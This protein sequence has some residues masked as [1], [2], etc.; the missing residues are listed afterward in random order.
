MLILVKEGGT[1]FDYKCGWLQDD[2][3]SRKFA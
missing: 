3:S 2:I 1:K